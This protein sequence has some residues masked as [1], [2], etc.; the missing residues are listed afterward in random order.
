MLTEGPLLPK[1]DPF[2]IAVDLKP[3]SFPLQN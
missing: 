3:Q 1:T 2:Y